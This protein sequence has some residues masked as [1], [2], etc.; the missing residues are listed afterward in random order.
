MRI[1]IMQPYLFPYIGYFQL[2]NAADK[3]VILDDVNY[4]NCGWIN[5]NRILI[6][7]IDKL[8]TLP[9][10]DA[11]QNK[12]INAIEILADNP[13]KDKLLKTL[14]LSYKKAPYFQVV[15][16][17]IQKIILNEERNLSAFRII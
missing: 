1:A 6:N 10:K 3:F 17:L 12:S 15:F 11:S 4:I 5:R 9:L 16:P 7:G 2:I 14:E 8:F 13:L